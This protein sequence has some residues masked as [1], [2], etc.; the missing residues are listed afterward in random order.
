[1]IVFATLFVC[2]GGYPKSRSD[3]IRWRH[4]Q[5]LNTT[6]RGWTDTIFTDLFATVQTPPACL[7]DTCPFEPADEDHNSEMVCDHT[8]FFGKN[9]RHHG[10]IFW[11]KQQKEKVKR[12]YN[13]SREQTQLHTI[14]WG[15]GDGSFDMDHGNVFELARRV[16]KYMP[17]VSR[18]FAANLGYNRSALN[19]VAGTGLQVLPFPMPFTWCS[20]SYYTRGQR[21]SKCPSRFNLRHFQTRLFLVNFKAKGYNDRDP[22]TGQKIGNDSERSRLLAYAASNLGFADKIG[23]TQKR[24][25]FCG[26]LELFAK[27][28]F[29]VSP[30]GHGIDCFRT[31]EAM[32]LGAVVILRIDADIAYRE[33]FAGLPAIILDKWEQL[34]ETFLQEAYQHHEKMVETNGYRLERLTSTYWR[35]LIMG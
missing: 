1:M 33:L 10:G 15:A 23:M 22:M 4:I 7:T 29:I 14:L 5:A 26:T 17:Q 34:T 27:Y 32:L 31:W 3:P 20:I 11:P 12:I 8:L 6:T 28:K 35:E 2:G 9:G 21:F 30:A 25:P 18:I 24:N 19:K 13:I 16:A